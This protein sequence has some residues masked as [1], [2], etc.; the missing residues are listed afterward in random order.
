VNDRLTAYLRVILI[1]SIVCNFIKL[2]FAQT[3]IVEKDLCL[4]TSGAGYPVPAAKLIA[5]ADNNGNIVATL[6]LSKS[7]ND[8]TYG[9][10][11]IGWPSGNHTKSR[12]QET[13]SSCNA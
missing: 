2:S 4:T 1:L 10:N 6:T 7:L 9:A 3:N 12:V 11:T 8:N 5:Y 13:M